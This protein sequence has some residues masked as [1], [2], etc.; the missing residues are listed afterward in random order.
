MQSTLKFALLLCVC[1]G[2]ASAQVYR[3]KDAKGV[4]HFSDTPPTSSITPD[5]I[6]TRAPPDGATAPELPFEVALAVKNHP[7]TL[8]TTGQ[9]AAC[10]QGRALLRARGIPYVEKTVTN[11]N[12]HAALRQA[13]GALQLPLL[14]VGSSKYVGFEQ[15]TWDAALTAA[16]YPAQTMLRPDYQPPAPVA[17]AQS[18]DT[19]PATPLGDNKRP[20]L[21]PP[22]PAPHF[23]F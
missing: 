22:K 2:V 21:P 6:D 20:V 8:Y 9:C 5:K 16:R 3:W 13:G 15:A 19:P 11:A 10:D 1:A 14:L 18:F 17:A 12:D 4:T 7:V 23:Q